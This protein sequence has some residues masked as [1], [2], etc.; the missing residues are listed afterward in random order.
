[1]ITELLKH[2][3][4]GFELLEVY[5]EKALSCVLKNYPF[6][7]KGIVDNYV[8]DHATKTVYINDL[9]TTGKNLSE[10][11]NTVD[12]YKYWMQG[13]IYIRLIK[14]N[15]PKVANYKFVMHFI[16]IDK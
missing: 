5:N 3:E 2:G 9:K 8:I 16:V 13:A 4:T 15:H 12:Y 7:L 10:F 6:G 11:K 1:T 14:S